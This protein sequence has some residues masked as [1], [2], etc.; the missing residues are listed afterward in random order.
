MDESTY[1]PT[2]DPPAD[3]K[4]PEKQGLATKI[5]LG[6]VFALALT[7]V[8]LQLS[9]SG[10]FSGRKKESVKNFNPAEPESSLLPVPQTLVEPPVPSAPKAP[11]STDVSQRAMELANRLGNDTT[12]LIGIVAELNDRLELAEEELRGTRALY[13]AA[14]RKILLLEKDVL[15]ARQQST[16]F[17][18][19]VA[20]LAESRAL[21]SLAE[22][23]SDALMKQLAASPDPKVLRDAQAMRDV[24]EAELRQT[25]GRL[26]ADEAEKARLRADLSAATSERAATEVALE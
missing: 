16:E 7:V 24:Y 2:P 15:T 18:Q 9:M 6:A 20:Q 23:R 13:A 21:L 26:A 22:R 14:A 8:I 11:K 10:V 17:D 19:L 1:S 25:K 12:S 5:I 4:P 3:A